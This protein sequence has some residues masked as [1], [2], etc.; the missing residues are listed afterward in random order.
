MTTNRVASV[1]ILMPKE[2]MQVKGAFLPMKLNL[3]N[4]A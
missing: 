1:W 3:C 2:P 4:N